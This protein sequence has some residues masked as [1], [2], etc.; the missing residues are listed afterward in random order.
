M[1]GGVGVVVDGGKGEEVLLEDLSE[2]GHHDT[3]YS[4][5]HLSQLSKTVETERRVS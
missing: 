4:R 5:K 3:P 2:H 1:L